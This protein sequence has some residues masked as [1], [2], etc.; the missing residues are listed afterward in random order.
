MATRHAPELKMRTLVFGPAPDRVTVNRGP[1]LIII[2]AV[3]ATSDRSHDLENIAEMLFA[4]PED[5]GDT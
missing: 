2:G 5:P 4:D 1:L 3:L